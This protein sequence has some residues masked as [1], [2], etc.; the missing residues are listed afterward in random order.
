VT[1]VE[2]Q[3]KFYMIFAWFFEQFLLLRHFPD[4]VGHACTVARKVILYRLSLGIVEPNIK[5]YLS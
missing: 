3:S 5:H 1:V 4:L 2:I